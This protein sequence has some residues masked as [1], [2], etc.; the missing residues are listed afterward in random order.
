MKRAAVI[1]HPIG[2]SKSP[3]IH[4]YWIN[5]NSLDANFEAIDI[6]PENLESEIKRLASEEYAGFS[7]TIPHKEK[8]LTLCDEVDATAKAIGAV[9][10]VIIKDGKL[11]GTNT[12]AFGFIENIRATRPGF[13]FASGPAVVLGAGG[14]ARA[15]IYALLKEGVPEIRLI[16]RTK[17]KAEALAT[18]PVKVQDW[19]QRSSALAEANLLVNTT[20]MGMKGQPKLEIDLS[21]LSRNTLVNDIVYAPLMTDL[22]RDAE[23]RGNPIVTGIGMLLHQ[24]APACEAWF[25]IKPEVDKELEKLVLS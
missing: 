16:N 9:N 2:H 25:G 4:N 10:A 8:I 15:V 6:A 3:L 7:V 18:G 14:A 24:A 22:L 17:T 1:G 19:E 13:D 11:H 5:K 21:A 20:S 12:D 23:D